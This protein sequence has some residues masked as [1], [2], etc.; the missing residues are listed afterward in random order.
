MSAIITENF[1][2]NNTSAFIAD[3]AVNNYYVGLG[4]SDKWTSDEQ[5]RPEVPS[6]IGTFLDEREIKSNL[7]SLIGVLSANAT[8]VVPNNKFSI[9]SIYKA[10]DPLNDNCFY[11][12]TVTAITSLPCYTTVSGNIFL[13]LYSPGTRTT[14]VPTYSSEERKY[15]PFSTSDG[16]I[17][18]LLDIIDANSINTVNTDQFISITPNTAAD[19]TSHLILAAQGGL[20]YGFTIIDGGTEYSSTSDTGFTY[21]YKTSDNT[22]GSI[23][24]TGIITSG[25]ITS[26]TITSGFI[27]QNILNVISGTLTLNT[28][29]STS[30]SGFKAIAKIAPNFGFAYQPYK[31]LPS[32]YAAISVKSEGLISGDGFY[33]PYRQISVLRNPDTNIPA[34]VSGDTLT[35]LRALPYLTLSGAPSATLVTGDILTINDKTKILFDYFDSTNYRLYYHQNNISDY[36]DTSYNSSKTTIFKNGNPIGATLQSNTLGEYKADSGDIIFVE[37][38]KAISR[39]ESQTE[40]IKIIIQF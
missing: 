29:D 6:P 5:A 7:I 12:S 36:G 23:P 25:S 40:E 17:W 1:R 13:C 35:S 37:N 8:K 31:I 20:L 16:Y 33:I 22:S 34:L 38:R 3:L 39:A 26:L 19:Y 4:K 9:S 24:V 28:A 27:T 18:V 10:Y 2:R 32:W 30:G 11:S 15:A 14:I 21:S